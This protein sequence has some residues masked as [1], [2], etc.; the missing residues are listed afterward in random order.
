VA[1]L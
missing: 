1:C